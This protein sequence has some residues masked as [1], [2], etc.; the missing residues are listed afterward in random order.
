MK[1]GIIGAMAEEIAL[2]EK[3]L[4][5]KKEWSQANAFFISGMVANHEVFLV[6]SGIGKVNSAIAATL[7][8]AQYGVE[9]VINTGSAGGIGKGL[10]VGDVVISTELAYHDVDATVF[11]YAIGQVPQM[12]ARYP[13]DKGL[14]EKTAEAAK[15]VGLAPVQGVIVTSDSFVAGKGAT[16][17]ILEHFPDAL[18]AEM[19]GAAIAQ[20]CFQFN[21]PFIIVRAMSDV[22]DEEAGVSFD[23]FIIEAGKQSAYM[24]LELLKAID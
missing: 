10:K 17:S 1:I 5:N 7:L 20:V 9:A 3:Q 16:A 11:G 2:L 23:E 21:K 4:T 24:V 19:E 18:A 12:P 14:M 15:A 13:A 6:Q 8:I 22:A